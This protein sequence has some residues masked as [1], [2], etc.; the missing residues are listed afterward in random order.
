MEEI[1]IVD[2]DRLTLKLLEKELVKVNYKVFKATS[3]KNAIKYAKDS[4]PSLILLDIVMPDMD[5]PQ[6][7]KLLK[8]DARTKDIPIIFI[9]AILSK[10]EQSKQEVKI[11]DELYPII[12]KPIDPEELKD[13]IEHTLKKVQTD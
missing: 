8:A 5:G 13:K 10:E 4:P 3:G 7:V 2:D 9:T 11:D 1:L 6:V 12:A